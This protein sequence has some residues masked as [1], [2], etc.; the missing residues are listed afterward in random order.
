VAGPHTGP[1]CHRPRSSRPTR[2]N[3]LSRSASNRPRPC[4]RSPRTAQE[5]GAHRSALHPLFSLGLV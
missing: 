5:R 2:A 1:T 3:P 4:T